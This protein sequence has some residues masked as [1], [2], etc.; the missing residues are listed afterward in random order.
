MFEHA[1]KIYADYG[2]DVEAAFKRLDNI[3]VSLH[4]WQGDDVFGF[5]NDTGLWR[6]SGGNDFQ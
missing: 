2:I 5:E 3:A 4:C 6:Q 1:K